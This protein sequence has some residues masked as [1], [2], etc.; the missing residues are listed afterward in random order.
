MNIPVKDFS[1]KPY[2]TFA[3]DVKSNYFLELNTV[4]EIWEFINSEWAGI[5]PRLILGGGSNI[6]FTKD[7]KG[8]ILH[9]KIKGISVINENDKNVWIRAGAG[10]NWDDFV[11]YCVDNNFG[12]LENLSLIPGNVGAS[13]I[14]NIGAYGVEAKESI[15]SVDIINLTTGEPKTYSNEEC[16]FSYR[17]SIFKSEINEQFIITH[18][19]FRLSKEHI[20]T[21]SYGSIEKE[22]DNYPE[23]TIQNIRKAVIAIRRSKLPDPEEF[24]NAGSFFKNPVVPNEI[25][26]SL[27]KFYPKAPNWKVSENEVKLSAA[28]LIETSNYKGKKI[29]NVSTY[30][31][32]P[33]V[34]INLGNATGDE[35]LQYSK[36]IQKTVLNHFAI[37]L[38]TEVNIF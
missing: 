17:N 36:R 32:Q 26:N 13:P 28:W 16:K 35:I 33:L 25:A 10:E 3:I 12:G 11:G 7:F 18:V 27:L 34:I 21:T 29:G 30:K 6:L 14:Q 15:E 31:K 24:G 23:T 8:I 1:L 22:L 19:V 4:D 38:E 9:P 5:S 2:N 20:F 37:T